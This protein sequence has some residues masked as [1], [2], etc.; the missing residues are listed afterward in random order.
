MKKINKPPGIHGGDQHERGR[1]GQTAGGP[2]DGHLTIFE[3]LA[4]HFEDVL[5]E[6]GQLVEKEHAVVGQTDLTG[7]GMGAAADQ[8]GVGNGV[9]G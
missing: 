6:L 5:L 1:I 2:A 7:A 3:G 4:Q 8:A 9:M